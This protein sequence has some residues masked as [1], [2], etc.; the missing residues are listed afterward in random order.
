MN[1]KLF[2]QF[3]LLLLAVLLLS[4][5][6]GTSAT[7]VAVVASTTTPIVVGFTPSDA[8][9]VPNVTGLD[10]AVAEGMLA[11]IGLQPVKSVQDD[12]SVAKGAIISQEPL[13]GKRLEPCS[14]D[15]IIVVSRGPLPKPTYTPA[16]PT[17]TPTST[18]V[19]PTSTFTPVPPTATITPDP[20]LFWDDFEEGIKPEWN[21]QGDGAHSI[22]GQLI[23]DG[24]AET[25]LGGNGWDNYAI[26]L[27]KLMWDRNDVR[28]RIREKDR[29]NY[30]LILFSNCKTCAGAYEYFECFIV[31]NGQENPIPQTKVDV[32]YSKDFRIEVEGN[33]Y[34]IFANGER[35]IFFVDDTYTTGGVNLHFVQSS[36]QTSM[37]AFEIRLW[38]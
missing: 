9:L 35:L 21:F 7:P 12:P 10:Q 26:T 36:G 13:A 14:G 30:L 33:K 19:P 28:V 4:A 1:R 29:D 23:V 15:V 24:Y 22:N 31:K 3:S 20:R 37:D 2:A 17:V 5:C 34:R 32:R 27:Y 38:P 18:L 8:C 6:A 25:N 11:E 16:P